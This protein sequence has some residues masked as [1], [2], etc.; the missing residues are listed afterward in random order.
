MTDTLIKEKKHT[1]EPVFFIFE[2]GFRPRFGVACS[3]IFY[4]T[5]ELLNLNNLFC[6]KK[7]NIQYK[8]EQKRLNIR[9]EKTRKIRKKKPVIQSKLI[10]FHPILLPLP[11]TRRHDNKRDK[12]TK[13]DGT[14]SRLFESLAHHFSGPDE[15]CGT[16]EILE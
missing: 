1:E 3:L 11:S 10:L 9:I 6:S 14:E 8:K 13:I 15:L 4:K 2:P 12:D 7:R 5:F 16:I